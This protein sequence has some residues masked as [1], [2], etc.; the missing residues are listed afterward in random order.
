MLPIVTRF[1]AAWLRDFTGDLLRVVTT[2]RDYGR[3]SGRCWAA[4]ATIA[5]QLGLSRGGVNRLLGKAEQADLVRS[6]HNPSTGTRNRWVRPMADDELAVCVSAHAR[7]S[8]SGTRFKVYCGLSLRE[9]LGETTSAR[10]LAKLSGVGAETARVVAA[11]LVADGW[12]SRTGDEGRAFRYTVHAVPLA[13]VAPQ[14]SLIQQPQRSAQPAAAEDAEADFPEDTVCPGQLDLSDSEQGDWTPLDLVTGTPLDSVTA[15]PPVL[16]ALTGSL[17]QDLVKK[18]SVRGGCSSGVADT[19]VPRGPVEDPA[20]AAE[21]TYRAG[22]VAPSADLQTQAPAPTKTP[23][24]SPMTVS[25]DIHQVLRLVPGLVARMSRW[26]QRESAR[27]IGAAI[28]EVG[29]DVERVV[30]RVERRYA[31]LLNDD[32]VRDPYAWLAHRAVRRRGCD[33]ASC[34]SGKDMDHGGDCQSCAF[35]I[36][37]AQAR[38]AERR[39]Q[40]GDLVAAARGCSGSE[41]GDGTSEGARPLAVAPLPEPRRCPRHRA[42][43]VPCGLCARPAEQPESRIRLADLP[44]SDLAPTWPVQADTADGVS[45]RE[46]LA[47]RRIARELAAAT[48]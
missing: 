5:E 29:G 33:L 26:Q 12:V 17:D 30:D 46:Q 45:L 9:H 25:A 39:Q 41:P 2:V 23:V 10:Q 13:V 24:L 27:A 34:E 37:G 44:P 36:E 6:E 32:E 20:A 48:R 43:A 1:P 14:L 31:L 16:I 8:L 21:P 28:R 38:H 40:R 15:T 22:V 47:A 35:R 42:T 11:E 18:P 7:A 3:K 4:D 19:S